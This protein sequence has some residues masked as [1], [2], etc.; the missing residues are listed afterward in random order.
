[1]SAEEP[2]PKTFWETSYRAAKKPMRMGDTKMYELGAHWLEGLFVE[3]WGCGLGWLRN[4]VPED[5][6]RGID[7][8]WSRFADEVVD[9]EQYR[10][11]VPAIFMRGVLEHN[12]GRERIL[13]NALASFTRRMALIIFTPWAEETHAIS[14]EPEFG[15]PDISF[16]REDIVERFGEVQ[17]TSEENVPAQTHYGL[18][19]LFLLERPQEDASAG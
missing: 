8:T 19:H 1:M 16:R 11:E 14:V 18:E 17:W 4:Y 3:D 6:Y 10:S 5:R 7:G 15:V 13:D 9:L 2:S 12:H